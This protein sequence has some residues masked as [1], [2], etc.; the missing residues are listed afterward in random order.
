M[1]GQIA[2]ARTLRALDGD[3]FRLPKLG[4]FFAI[5]ILAA[6]TWWFLTPS[7]PDYSEIVQNASLQWSGP[8]RVATTDLRAVVPFP[9]SGTPAQLRS[10]GQTIRARVFGYRLSMTPYITHLLIFDVPATIQPPLPSHAT[11]EVAS[12]RVSPAALLIR[13]LLR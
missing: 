4:L 10:E 11:I 2:F 7:I 9:K 6:W 5:A 8:H 1:T 3:N 13:S 12:G